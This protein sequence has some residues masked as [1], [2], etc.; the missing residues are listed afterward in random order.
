MLE[1]EN[2][3]NHIQILFSPWATAWFEPPD[4]FQ[5]NDCLTLSWLPLVYW[6]SSVR[7]RNRN[8]PPTRPGDHAQI[9]TVHPR[10]SKSN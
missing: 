3:Q 9:C 7:A 6:W 8:Q 1:Q 4:Y 5:L 2:L 10:D